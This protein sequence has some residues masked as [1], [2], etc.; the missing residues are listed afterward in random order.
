MIKHRTDEDWKADQLSTESPATPTPGGP[1]TLATQ[2][3][4]LPSLRTLLAT[5][6]PPQHLSLHLHRVLI[7]SL[8]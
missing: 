5:P 4:L 1:L 7:C 8:E 2:G 3:Q 6:P